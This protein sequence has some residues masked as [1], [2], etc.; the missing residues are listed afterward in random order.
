MINAEKRCERVPGHQVVKMSITMQ[1]AENAHFADG[2][3]RMHF[4]DIKSGL[5]AKPLRRPSRSTPVRSD[6]KQ[7]ASSAALEQMSAKNQPP[8]EWFDEKT[9]PFSPEI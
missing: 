2:T 1:P 7:S 6:E 8:Q 5:S 9:D 3:N 4:E